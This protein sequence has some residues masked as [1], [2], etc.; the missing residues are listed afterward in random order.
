MK[1]SIPYAPYAELDK[2]QIAAVCKF[3]KLRNT[4]HGVRAIAWWRVGT[5]KTRLAYSLSLLLSAYEKLPWVCAIIARPKAEYDWKAEL[6]KLGCDALFTTDPNQI[7]FKRPTFLFVSFGSVESLKKKIKRIPW[8]KF[9]IIDEL[10]LFS[11][12][13]TKRSRALQSLTSECQCLGMGGTIL[14]SKDNAQV[15]GQAVAVGIQRKLA[16]HLSEYRS[17]YQTHFQANFGTRSCMQFKNKANWKEQVV[18]K[19]QDRVS[20]Y[21]PSE[22]QRITEQVIKFPLTTQQKDAIESLTKHYF[23]ECQGCEFDF[24]YAFEVYSKIRSILNGWIQ[25]PSGELLNVESAKL[26]GLLDSLREIH[27]ANEPCVVWCAFRND[28][29]IIQRHLDFAT[30]QMVGGSPFDLDSFS[31]GKIRIVLATMGSGAS[32]NHFRDVA[33]AKFFSLSYKRL[34][35]QQSKGRHTRR[36]SRITGVHYQYFECDKSYDTDIRKHLTTTD[37]E[38]KALI[39]SWHQKILQTSTLK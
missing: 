11:N 25:T 3:A 12:P 2:E 13:K 29:K 21:F 7:S 30:L 31:R 19:L 24:K 6:E 23:L 28:I 9:I 32:V 37:N 34:D 15:W 17:I 1:L 22:L 33:I 36:D 8:L 10:Y 39:K 27:A 16:K 35:L 20:I 18:A 26:D 14:T 4:V 38:E 5:G